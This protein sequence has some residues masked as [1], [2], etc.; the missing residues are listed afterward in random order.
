MTTIITIEVLDILGTGKCSIGQKIGTI[1]KYPE[2]RGKLCPSSY[3]ILYPWILVLQ[4]GGK[5]SFM[6]DDSITL[7]CSDY[8]HQVVYKIT[9]KEIE[10]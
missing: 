7:G 5:F 8:H 4:S 3:H 2:D 6:E 10:E 1:Y 9:R